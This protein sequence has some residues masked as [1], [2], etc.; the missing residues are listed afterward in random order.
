MIPAWHQL[1][2]HGEKL[3]VTMFS[4]N[5]PEMQWRID[6]S[7]EGGPSGSISAEDPE[8]AWGLLESII[9]GKAFTF[10]EL[11]ERNNVDPRK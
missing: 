6:W 9:R 2:W 4:S 8:R 7:V 11:D 1:R 10:K 5:D 3:Q